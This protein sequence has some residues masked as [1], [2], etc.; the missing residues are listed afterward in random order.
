[1]LYFCGRFRSTADN[2]TVRYNEDLIRI[3]FCDIKSTNEMSLNLQ[4]TSVIVHT[5]REGAEIKF[6][7]AEVGGWGGG[8]VILVVDY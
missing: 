2:S 4:C 6:E 8:G 1:M 3:I 5:Q 7:G